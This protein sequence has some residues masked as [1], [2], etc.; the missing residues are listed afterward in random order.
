MRSARPVAFVLAVP[1]VVFGIL[2]LALWAPPAAAEPAAQA[3]TPSPAVYL[4]L[5]VKPPADLPPSTATPADW[6]PAAGSW[7]GTNEQ[8]RPLTFTVAPGQTQVTAL[9]L[10]VHHDDACGGTIDVV[11]DFAPFAIDGRS[12]SAKAGDSQIVGTFTSPTAASGVYTSVVQIFSPVRCTATHTGTWTAGLIAGQSTPTP[13]GTASA[14]AT[15]T[16][17]AT[18]TNDPSTTPITTPSPTPSPTRTVCGAVMDVTQSYLNAPIVGKT[19]SLV[20]GPML[21]QT[22][23]PAP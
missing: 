8:D 15:A 7:S 10:S 21:C 23:L 13:T 4:P 18:A 5:A 1:A 17:S 2:L 11:H 14:T 9:Q 6:K 3:G 20:S 19:F 22:N 12:F 16:A